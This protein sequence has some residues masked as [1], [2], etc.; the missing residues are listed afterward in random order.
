MFKDNQLFL[1]SLK[2][3]WRQGEW[4]SKYKIEPNKISLRRP[5]SIPGC[6]CK[7]TDQN[8]SIN[9]QSKDN[10][11]SNKVELNNMKQEA[12]DCLKDNR[13]NENILNFTDKEI[14][15]TNIDEYYK[16]KRIT[17]NEVF[18]T[19]KFYNDDDIEVMD[20]YETRAKFVRDLFARETLKDDKCD[21]GC[22][23]REDAD[24]GANIDC[25]CRSD[26]KRCEDGS[27]CRAAQLCEQGDA[28]RGEDVGCKCRADAKRCE[29]GCGCICDQCYSSCWP[30][31]WIKVDYPNARVISINYTS[32]PHLWRPLWIK[33]NKR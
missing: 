18:I 24:R 33:E 23:W 16:T 15:F 28:K 30:K 10:E 17:E 6:D 2:N 8:Y 7:Q 3:T 5:N 4:R 32:D 22:E 21:L 27:G 9:E 13:E 11:H 31:D 12:I 14:T 25:R 20:S 19:E 1:G 29:V 26:A